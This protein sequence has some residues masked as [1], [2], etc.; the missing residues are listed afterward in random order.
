VIQIKLG[1]DGGLADV[2]VLGRGEQWPGMPDEARA[3]TFF[4]WPRR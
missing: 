2:D 1:Q 4:G 3:K